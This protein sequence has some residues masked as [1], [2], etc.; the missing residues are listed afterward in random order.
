MQQLMWAFSIFIVMVL[1]VGPT[2]GGALIWQSLGRTSSVTFGRCWKIYLAACCYTALSLLIWG[3]LTRDYK[4]SAFVGAMN[5]LLVF[6]TPLLVVPLFTRNYSRPALVRQSI[7]VVLA[8]GI[9]F[10]AFLLALKGVAKSGQVAADTT[11]TPTKASWR[12]SAPPGAS[13]TTRPPAK[14]GRSLQAEG[15]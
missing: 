11:P 5:A 12:G 7:A 1:F 13:G 14:P 9:I 3:F 6:G 2:I 8:Q 4:D 10:V 15:E